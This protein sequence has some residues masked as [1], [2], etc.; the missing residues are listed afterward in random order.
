M[1][2]R[3]IVDLGEDGRVSVG[4]VLDGELPSPGNPHELAWPLDG[5]A[6]EDLRWYLEEYLLWPYAVYEDR[7]EEI[8][9]ALAEWGRAVFLSVFGAGPAREAYLRARMRGHPELVFR[10]KSSALLGLPWELMADPDR[11]MPLA[12]DIA[13][14]SRSLR[15]TEAAPETVRARAGGCGC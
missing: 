5:D 9:A 8:Q 12:L 14:V 11:P 2:D 1:P 6:L 3:L 10:S 7:G 13:G 4:T 15:L